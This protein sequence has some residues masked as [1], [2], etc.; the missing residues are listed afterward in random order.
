[1]WKNYAADYLR[2]NR[3]GSSS[4]IAASIIAALFLSLLCSLFYNFWLDSIEGTRQE[5]GGWHGRIAAELSDADLEKIYAFENVEKAVIN[6]YEGTVEICFYNRRTVYEDMQKIVSSLGLP[7]DAADYNYQLLSLYFVRIPGDEM[8]RLLMPA[9]LAIITLVC[10]SLIL[11]IHNSFAVSMNNRVRQFGIF[12]SIGATPKQIRVCLLQEAFALSVLPVL[13]GTLLGTV[14]SFGIVSAMGSFAAGFAGGRRMGFAWHPA[15]LTLIL[16]LS[17]FTVCLSARIPAGRLSR[18]T[19]LEAIR[20]AGELQLRKK[21]HT[22]VLSGLF[23]AE[24]EL[25][26]AALSAQRKA[27][28]T[29]TVSLT[30]AFLGFM[31]MQCFFTLSGISTRHTYF[32]AY[33]DAWDVY[34]TVK[35][36]KIEEFEPACP[37]RELKGAESCVIYQ[38]G[39]AMSMIP[40][41]DISPELYAAGGIEELAGIPLSK[42]ENAYLVETPLVIMDDRSFE[43]YCRR[44]GAEAGAAAEGVVVLNRIWNSAESNFRYPEYIP[45]IKEGTEKIALRGTAAVEVPVLVCTQDPPI[46]RE[47]YEKSDYP[48]VQ[49]VSLS[50]WEEALDRIGG[51]EREGDVCIRV[52]AE[53]RESPAALEALEESVRQMADG[54]YEMES[55]NRIQEKKDNDTMIWG[56]ELILGGLCALLAAIGIAHVFSGTAGFLRQRKREF[57]RYMSVGLTPEGVRKIFC[58]EAL[59]IVGRPLLA[60]LLLTTVLTSCMIRAS[61]LDPMEFISGAPVLPILAFVLAVSAS[62][63]L[64]Y[65]LGGRRILRIDLAESLRND[66]ML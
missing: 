64:A 38:K 37:V 61:Y 20:G 54:N 50:Y 32:E 57:A 25:A 59:A 35:D 26:G 22:P 56:Y 2:N 7:A 17:F 8:P 11:V 60:A 27:L 18:L 4:V 10:I 66:T 47:E 45:Y 5:E 34:V 28:R 36:A 52:L 48:L 9:Y 44:I 15:V 6:S 29:T 63:A 65:L 51:V 14:F 41:E 33:Q 46:L 13:A 12:S 58:I 31:L 49:F 23:G 24:G 3:P 43:E 21:K 53:N 40:A 62:V 42:E 39:E 19:P 30:L 55:E 16:L 1:M